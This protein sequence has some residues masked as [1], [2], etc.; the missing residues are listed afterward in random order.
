MDQNSLRF[1]K[2]VS[3]FCTDGYGFV[4]ANDGRE[5]YFDDVSTV[6]ELSQFAV[7]AEVQFTEAFDVGGVRASRV[8]LT[9]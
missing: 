6:E 8:Q 9:F 5:Y 3:V 2:I 1:G 7:G 4:K